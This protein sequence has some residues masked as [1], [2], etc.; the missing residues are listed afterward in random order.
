M[1]EFEIPIIEKT[2]AQTELRFGCRAVVY[3]VANQV[4]GGGFPSAI[5]AIPIIINYILS[6]KGQVAIL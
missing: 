2:P 4:P 6:V 3:E 1:K 5:S